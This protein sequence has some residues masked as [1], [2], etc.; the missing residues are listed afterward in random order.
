M[1]EDNQVNMEKMN[2]SATPV[3]DSEPDD[4]NQIQYRVDDVP[5]WYLCLFLGFQVTLHL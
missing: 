3:K 2:G 5:A 1:F 4:P